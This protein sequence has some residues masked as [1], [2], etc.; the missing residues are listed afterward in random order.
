MSR[1]DGCN[2][3][4]YFG[5][6][7]DDD[8]I[9]DLF[10]P[11]LEYFPEDA[12]FSDD[13][14]RIRSEIEYKESTKEIAKYTPSELENRYLYNVDVQKVRKSFENKK[15]VVIG[16]I[17]KPE[18][19]GN[20]EKAFGC[21]VEWRETSHGESLDFYLPY[22]SNP[23]VCAFMILIQLA[24]HKHSQELGALA[25]KAG[26]PFFRVHTTNPMAAAKEIVGQYIEE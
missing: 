21:E 16:G 3:F 4:S 1:N 25:R 20:F 26:T 8:F 17:P 23:D 9:C 14:Y 19:K 22:L 24:S 13:F 2:S 6:K 5:Y 10:R 11:Y 12:D 18:Q 7:P 15:L